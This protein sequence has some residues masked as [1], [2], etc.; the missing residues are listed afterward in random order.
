MEL[1]H[2]YGLRAVEENWQCLF[3]HAK[4]KAIAR[5]GFENEGFRVR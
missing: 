2:E 4:T 3:Y 1:R 5:V